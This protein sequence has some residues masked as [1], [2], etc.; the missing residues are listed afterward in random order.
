MKKSLLLLFAAFATLVVGCQKEEIDGEQGSLKVEIDGI[1]YNLNE[2]AKQAEVRSSDGTEYSGSITIP[3]TVTHKGVE[4]SVTSIGDRAF[5]V[6]SLRCITIPEGVTSIGE[7]AFY[8]CA[9]LTAIIIPDNSQLTSIGDRAFSVCLSLTAINIPA[10]VTSIG[11][12][13]F[14][15]CSLTTITIP[16]GVT[17]IGDQAF[18]DC[19][20]LT[21]ITLPEGVT[22]IGNYAFEY[23]RSLTA[24]TL[25]ESVTSIGDQAFLDCTRLTSITIPE[26]SQLTNIGY[27]AFSGC[28][29]L[30]TITIPESVTSIGNYAF[31]GCSRLTDITVASKNS[32][33]DSRNN[34]NAIIE[35]NSNTL[36][37]GC[38]STIIPESVTS[39]GGGAF[40]G[41]S[42]LTAIT[43]PEGVTSIGGGAFGGCSNLTAIT[44]PE[45]VTSI[46][47]GAFGGCRSL[48]AITIPEDSKLT[49][50]GDYA[51]RDCRSLTAITL[52]ESVTSIGDLAFYD[53]SGLKTV[54]NYSDLPIQRGYSNYGYVARYADRVIN[55][56]EVID[57][58]A[59]KTI[60]GVH[61]LSGYTGDKTELTL[62]ADYKGENYQIG[63]RAF[64]DCSSLTAI[65]IPEGVT[66]IGD[67]AFGGC[68]SLESLHIGPN[69]DSYGD[70][71]FEGC[72][73]IKELTVMGNVMPEIPSEN[74][75]FITLYSPIPLVTK[76]F[77][78]TV[79]RN[80]ILIIPKGSLTSYRNADVWGKFW[81][82]Y[83]FDPKEG[84][85]VANTTAR[86][87]S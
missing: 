65:N 18:Q 60:E 63:D 30:T 64:E 27:S 26:N 46:G 6:C 38:S 8:D 1:W 80:V 45:G 40:S 24:I 73:A 62:P 68:S 15:G 86:Y 14:Y 77:A 85:I 83:G 84:T 74:L 47:G 13:A 41:C 66:S 76:E 69:V 70:K 22:S 32:V 34:C 25:P 71:V 52:P 50:I 5:S 3:A 43:I 20:S 78:S 39:I 12:E 56:D 75:M 67:D 4:Y 48:T 17:S 51:F 2:S 11:D 23:C 59:F 29:S 28:S 81:V 57:G 21:A 19:S 42:S 49:S 79:Y 87:T 72:T 10:G 33:Y 44:I 53:C 9:L 36:I 54:I 7:D 61:Y 35:T 58:Y 55:V 16:E 37:A 82:I 31:S